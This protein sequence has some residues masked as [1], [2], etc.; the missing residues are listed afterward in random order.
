MELVRL[1]EVDDARRCEP[2]FV[3]YADWVAARLRDDYGI[4]VDAAPHHEA[5]RTEIPT[6]EGQ[7]DSGNLGEDLTD[8]FV[9][10]GEAA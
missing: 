2:L 5:F 6:A 1:T 3:E 7:G 4:D 8:L 9:A 10:V